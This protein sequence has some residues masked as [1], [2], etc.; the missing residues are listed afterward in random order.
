MRNR[1]FAAA[2]AAASLFATSGIARKTTEPF[3][4][5]IPSQDRITHALNRLTFG[6]RPGDVDQ[7][8]KIGLKKWIDR[9]LHPDRIPENPLLL[10]KLKYLDSLSMTSQQLVANYPAPQMIRQLLAAKAPLPADPDRR[11][12]IQKLVERY[13]RRQNQN[14]ASQ[15]DPNQEIANLL[16][17]EQIR[18][19][20]NGAPE[21]RL[22]ALSSLPNE[23]LDEVLMALPQGVRQRLFVAAPPELRRKIELTAG[24]QQVVARDL[25]E[26]KLLRAIYSDRQ[27]EEVLTDFWF[28][29]FNVY[30]DK[31]ADRWLTTA[32]ERDVIRRHVLGKFRDLLEATAKSPAMLFYLDN[33]QSVGPD[34]P[35]ARAR[36][37]QRRGLNE[38]YGRELMELHTLG[39][40]GGYTQH[41]VT[42][43]A[44]CFTGWTI[45]RPNFG[46][47]FNFN[48]RMHD[49]GEKTVLGVKIPA[50]GGV[51][52]GEK[53]L[54][55]VAH[56][57]A[58]AQFVSRKLAIRFVSD[59]PPQP[60]VDHM[61][62]TFL[63]TGGD[64][65]EVM[66]TMFNSKEFWSQGAYRS[67]MKSPLEFVAGSVRAL[68]GDVDFAQALVNQVAQLGEPLYRKQEPTGYSNAGQ[69]WLNSASLVARMNFALDLTH[70]RVP[71]VKIAES[72]SPADPS[73]GMTLGSPDFQKR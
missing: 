5:P 70:N 37:N 55:I 31:G 19:L 34:A 2:L 25:S 10:E 22:A 73:A 3:Q 43:V 4:Q 53:V 51:N 39:V 11:L 29:H 45:D 57:P 14:G 15:P 26:G 21:E 20:R 58:T 54:D 23:K 12:L 17:R 66:K 64:L 9:Q 63:D 71:G 47:G 48:A 50:G 35:L 33:W 1:R 72:A 32:Y 28:N 38:N 16:T 42:E 6:P 30:L 8:Q 46:G 60:L 41:D 67:K 52:D 36:G 44:R 61:A 49:T 18:S 59:N 40:D 24:P 56:H 65:R 68:H 62:K 27:L 7:V 69:E 13:E